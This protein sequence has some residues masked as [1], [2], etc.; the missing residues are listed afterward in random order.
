MPRRISPQTS[1]ENLKKEAKRRLKAMRQGD[2]DAR[3]EFARAFPKG[4]VNP[5]LR[6]VQHAMALEFGLSGWT[7]LKRELE[8][9]PAKEKGRASFTPADVAV[10]EQLAKDLVLAHD[11]DDAAALDRLNRHYERTFTTEDVRAEIWRRLYSFRRRSR[12]GNNKLEPP[13]AQAILA[14][15]AGYPSWEAL[16][17][18][19]ATGTPPVAGY[20]VDAKHNRTEPRRHL[21]PSEW[22]AL[23]G[24]MKD[25][26]ITSLRAAGWMT[27]DVLRRVAELD[28]VTYLDLV[29]SQQLT[30]AGYAHLSKMPQLEWLDIGGKVTDRGLEV[31]RHLP[32]LK[33]FAAT[34]HKGITDAGTANLRFCDRLEYANLMG[35]ST[36]DATV[37]ALRGKPNFR[38]LNTGRLVTDAGLKFLRDFPMFTTPRKTKIDFAVMGDIAEAVHLLLDGPITNE[39]LANL[40][41]LDGLEQ[42]GLFWNTTAITSAGLA[43]VTAMKSLTSLNCDGRICDDVAMRHFAAIP[44][45]K[46]LV[47]QEAVA[48]EDGWIALSNSKTLEFLWGRECPNFASRAFVAF[49]KMPKLRALGIGCANVDDAALATLPRFPSLRE[50]TAIGFDDEGFRHIGRCERLERLLCMYCQQTGDAAT[51]HLAGLKRLKSYYAGVT[52][53]TDRSLEI[54]GGMDSLEK[55]EFYECIGISDKGLKHLARLPRLKQIDISASPKVTLAGTA[56]FPASVQVNY[57]IGG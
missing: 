28:H 43:H 1:L 24:L 7:E 48:S 45:L 10:L 55:V 14:Q 21:R 44:R 29:G 33:T 34:W 23:L 52:K 42:L 40:R 39:G 16:T 49:S 25:R 53:I 38:F 36:G 17:N 27:D 3:Q 22:D 9:R 54:L 2:S 5:G 26:R 8:K 51:E 32:H 30:D 12:S 56:V 13:E 47:A 31:L 37:D 15:D 41:G 18:A 57:V 35:T 46:K 50:I 6:D 11:E 4:P 19:A 20:A